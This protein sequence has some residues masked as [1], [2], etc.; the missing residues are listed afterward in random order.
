LGCFHR[1]WK[2]VQTPSTILSFNSIFGETQWSAV[3]ALCFIDSEIPQKGIRLLVGSDDYP[4][5][6]INGE[7]IYSSRL[8][9]DFLEDEDIVEGLNLNAGTNILV[10]TVV[11]ETADWKGSIRLTG[12]AGGPLRQ[13]KISS[14]PTH[15]ATA[16]F[17]LIAN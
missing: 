5:V 14:D 7:R 9:R 10:F 11:N 13:V 15:Q 12:R 17:E 16:P 3:H 2:S 6:Q 1:P 8:N 4:E